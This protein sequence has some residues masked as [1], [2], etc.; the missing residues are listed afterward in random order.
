VW[1][2]ALAV[3]LSALAQSAAAVDFAR[4]TPLF[5]A[6]ATGDADAVFALSGVRRKIDW[7]DSNGFTALMYASAASRHEL[8]GL[9]LERGANP[10]IADASGRTSL[11][12]AAG[13]APE[14]LF[15]VEALSPETADRLVRAG[16]VLDTRDR[17]G[18]TPLHCSVWAGRVDVARVLLEL[19]ADP[20]IRNSDDLAPVDLASQG[21]NTGAFEEL[22]ASTEGGGGEPKP[23]ANPEPGWAPSEEAARPVSLLGGVELPVT[24]TV[25]VP[26]SDDVAARG[27]EPDVFDGVSTSLEIARAETSWTEDQECAEVRASFFD[28]WGDELAPA[29]A[30]A[31]GRSG[32][33]EWK[34]DA[35]AL[36]VTMKSRQGTDIRLHT[37][38]A[39]LEDDESAGGEW[40]RLCHMGFGHG[41]G[42]GTEV[43][44]VHFRDALLGDLVVSFPSGPLEAAFR[45]EMEQAILY[46]RSLPDPEALLVTINDAGLSIAALVEP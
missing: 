21:V 31:G 32:Y 43:T 29:M 12:F 23:A 36:A 39:V 3:A 17:Y 24:L 37:T 27:G 14:E 5:D 9:L 1:I 16:A 2:T 26:R 25:F 42:L 40:V 18:N 19:G 30:L 4:M 35:G 6:A 10:E 8:I 34:P 44:S 28:G 38:K 11:H 7:Q 13:C 15:P 20:G 45:G 33:Q 41:P 46:G 22:F